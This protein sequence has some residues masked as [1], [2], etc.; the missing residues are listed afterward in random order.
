MA[1]KLL[2]LLLVVFVVGG[3]CGIGLM[4]MLNASRSDEHE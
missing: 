2:F 3:M 4:A 1:C